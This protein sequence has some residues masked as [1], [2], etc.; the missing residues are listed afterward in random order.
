M[1][2]KLL[3]TSDIHLSFHQK[4]EIDRFLQGVKA[5]TPDYVVISGDI[6]EAT[7]VLE[8]L[9][10][11][12]GALPCP[13]YFVLGNHDYY[14]GSIED[15]RFMMALIS[16]INPKLHWLPNHGVIELTP[17]TAILGHGAY[18]DARFG[19]YTNSTLMLN[20]Y[21]HIAEFKNL[22]HKTRGEKLNALGD[23]AAAYFDMHLPNAMAKYENLIVVTHPPPFRE[24]TRHMGKISDDN[25]LP[26]FSC[27]AVGDALL[28]HCRQYPNCSV[29]VLCG[30][31]H[32]GGEIQK[33]PNL[34]V[35][36][37]ESDY[38]L[39][40]EDVFELV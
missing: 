16:S 32:G 18:Q 25:G 40:I 15:V 37:S 24:V 1:P 23:E 31:T 9:N 3:W 39:R 36:V 33:L 17:K 27:K 2:K 14:G 6:G 35:I 19:D 7:S 4:Q 30:H 11:I 5:N 29:T 38:E 22:D 20:D 26:H 34:H 12:A 8:Y 10:Y 21:V 13:I 28:K